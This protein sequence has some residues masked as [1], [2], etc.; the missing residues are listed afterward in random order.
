MILKIHRLLRRPRKRAL[1]A[2]PNQ[3]SIKIIA[4]RMETLQVVEVLQ[5]KTKR[6]RKKFCLVPTITRLLMGE[7]SK[8]IMVLQSNAN[9][10]VHHLGPQET[11]YH[12]GKMRI[13]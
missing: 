10:K 3:L 11:K 9:K 13:I 1:R 4:K 8:K 7:I 2:E 12:L 6:R 5:V